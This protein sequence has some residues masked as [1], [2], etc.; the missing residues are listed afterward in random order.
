[1][2]GKCLTQKFFIFKCKDS[3]DVWSKELCFKTVHAGVI[4]LVSNNASVEF[5]YESLMDGVKEYH[6]SVLSNVEINNCIVAPS[7]KFN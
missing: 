2:L 7:P 1:M 6:A 3:L 4:K 5:F